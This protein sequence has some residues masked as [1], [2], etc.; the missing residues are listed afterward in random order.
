MFDFRLRLAA[1]DGTPGRVLETLTLSVTGFSS[2]SVRFAVTSDVA[3]SLQAPFLV[4][5]EY[6]TSPSG[7]WQRIPRNDLYIADEESG[8]NVDPSGAVSFTGENVFSWLTARYPLWW[9]VGD[10]ADLMRGY[11]NQTPGWVLKDIITSA[12]EQQGWGPNVSLGF[13]IA[14]DSAGNPWSELVTQKWPLF[15][16]TLSRVISGLAEQ[17]Y[18]EWWSEGFKLRAVNAGTG[19][20]RSDA[21]VLGGPGF[22]RAP[23]KRQFDQATS[24]VVQYD[25]GWTHFDNPGATTRFGGLFKVMSQSGAP[26]RAAAEASAQPALAEARAT[27]EELTYE[28]SL[29]GPDV[30]LPW[31]DFLPGDVVTA[32]TRRG[33]RALRVIGLDLQ[34]DAKGKV[35]ATAVVGSKLLDLQAKLAKRS[36]AASV[37]QIIGGSGSGVPPTTAPPAA[38]PLPPQGLHVA[39]NVGSW[40]TDGSAV[41]TVALEWSAVSQAVDGFL[42]DVNMYELWSRTASTLPSLL[43]RTQDPTAVT[44]AFPPAELRLVKVRARSRQ[45][46]WGDFSPEIP[47]TPATPA[48]IVPKAPTGL[49]VS[50]N[51]ASFAT[52]GRAIAQITFT[53]NA[54]TQSTDNLPLGVDAYRAEVEDGQ[55]WVPLVEVLGPRQATLTVLSGV[56][57]RVRV[58]ARSPLGVWGDPSAI[59]SATGAFP[60]AITAAPSKPTLTTGAGGAFIAWDGLLTSGAPPSGFQAVYAEAK[61]GTAAWARVS[62]PLSAGAGQVAQVRATVGTVV[63]A[64]LVL[65]DTLGRVGA[66]SEVGQVT[67]TGVTSADID[68]AV[69]DAI[70]QAQATASTANGRVTISASAPV[71]GDGV[72]RP[73]GALWYRRDGAGQ[74]IGMWEWSGS[75]WTARTLT[76]A[77]IS[78]LNAGTITAGFLD[79]ARV[80]VKS[81]TAEKLV[82]AATGN[83]IPNGNFTDGLAGWASGSTVSVADT[84]ADGPDG[85]AATIMRATPTSADQALTSTAYI[86]SAAAGTP[87]EPGTPFAFRMRARVVSGTA[88]SVRVR[89]G[90]HG[91]GQSNQFRVPDGVQLDAATAT[92]GQ[93]VTLEGTYTTPT[94]NPRDRMSVGLHYANAAGTVFEVAE[95]TMRPMAS[96]KL[97]VDGAV[98]AR[99]I[100][101]EAVT[102]DKIKAGSISVDKVEPNFGQ[103]LDIA[104]NGSVNI[105]VTAQQ[106]QQQQ[107]GT[108]Q[109]TASAA[110]SAAQDAATVAGDAQAGVT[111]VQGQ[112]TTLGQK[113]Q[114]TQQQLGQVSMYY[115]FGG[116]GAIIGRSDSPTQFLLRNTGASIRVNGVDVS[117]WDAGQMIVPS[118]VTETVVL[119]AH[120]IEKVGARTVFRAITQ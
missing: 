2:Q 83:L 25:L 72:G 76:D 4:L 96:A 119:S 30:P 90:F 111:N 71:A 87:Y 51:T 11:T 73:V 112:V 64:R 61:I 98:T 110:A 80:A 79:A 28:W 103:N 54:V 104:A 32:R 78:N 7:P 45:G 82:I 95:V 44:A 24:L 46:V 55:E 34:K 21:V 89:L 42:V 23:S 53:W 74:V 68:Q 118:L 50:A 120:R 106:N 117:T 9:R 56:A 116:D 85:G 26:T 10:T 100:A 27:Q 36:A 70:A 102:A 67:V 63:Q 43:L 101:A 18:L 49:A 115:R 59:V 57:R 3:G 1:D 99:T 84:V 39:S 58:R 62:G 38:A 48:S 113:Q 97:I 86:G 69:T 15:T 105:I 6:T 33:K 94:G 75:A 35:T 13:G 66:T 40:A 20:D 37:G 31:R 81:L 5:L 41:S 91:I 16:T 60:A 109:D 22:T 114:A 47:V 29:A 14:N 12:K 92:P 107:I 65:L 52:D 88:G 19:T 8:D 17:G 108:A 77:V 93:W